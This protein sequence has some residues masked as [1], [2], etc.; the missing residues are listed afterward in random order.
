MCA[1]WAAPAIIGAVAGA[2][3]SGGKSKAA[4]ASTSTPE[5]EPQSSGGLI[6]PHVVNAIEKIQTPTTASTTTTASG[7]TLDII[8]P[9]AQAPQPKAPLPEK[10]A[11]VAAPAPV[12][13]KSKPITYSTPRS[14]GQSR[15]GETYHS[16][17]KAG[18]PTWESANPGANPSVV[19]ASVGRA[20]GRAVVGAPDASPKVSAKAPSRKRS[21]KRRGSSALR[22]DLAQ[23]GGNRN[24][25]Y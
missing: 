14:W 25:N 21:A 20:Q 12:I 7:K 23:S 15:A 4:S 22:I 11:T 17:Q 5:P 1:P 10:T 13:E 24:L 19:Q 6:A 18:N 8:P 16:Q 2:V 3:L 9:Q